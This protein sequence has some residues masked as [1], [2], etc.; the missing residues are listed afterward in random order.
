MSSE[1]YIGLMSGTSMDGIDAALLQFSDTDMELIAS[2]SQPWPQGL[3]QQMLALATPGENEIDR[4]GVLDALAG[5]QF[6]AAALQLLDKT[7][8]PAGDITAIGSHGQTIRHRPGASPPFSLQIGDPNRI[9][10]QTGITTIA[11]FR[12]RDMAAGGEGAP[13]VPAF[14]ADIF[15]HPDEARAILNIGGIANLTLLPKASDSTVTGFDTG[16]GNCL[17]DS[18]I[19]HHQNQ[20]YDENGDWAASGKPDTDLLATLLSDSYF[21]RRS[22]K[23]TGPEYFSL[24]WLEHHISCQPSLPPEDI[25]ATLAALTAESI[26]RALGDAAPDCRRVLVCGGGVHNSHLMGALRA[27]LGQTQLESTEAYGLH[28]DWVEAAAFAWLARRTLRGETG[29]LSSVTG[30]SHASILGGIYPA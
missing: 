30:A 24:G 7:G 15:Q 2:H 3:R 6:A 9:A 28:P 21:Q 18:W 1:L 19:R 22:P 13:L 4:L 29:N 8:I 11:D 10:E 27:Q 26:S 14:H 16:P 12:R 23:S 20:P 5:Q 17:L 25:Q